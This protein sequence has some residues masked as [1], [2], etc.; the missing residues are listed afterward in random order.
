MGMSQKELPLPPEV[1][2]PKEGRV[3]SARELHANRAET[4][5]VVKHMGDQGIWDQIKAKEV[6]AQI[7]DYVHEAIQAGFELH[8]VRKQLGI[9][10]STDKAW[11]KINAALL[12]G[13]RIDSGSL[14]VRVFSKNNRILA[15][16]DE[17]ILEAFNT[18]VPVKQR[19]GSYEI[20]KGPTKELADMIKARTVVE[21]SMIRIGKDLGAFVDRDSGRGN[22]GVTIVVKSG[23]VLPT[24]TQVDEANKKTIEISSEAVGVK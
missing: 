8:H 17:Q 5:A 7:I 23:V 3:K 13:Y 15:K 14:L 6:P 20:V 24:Q 22:S 4:A 21:Q 19:D 18:G 16:I 1:K 2:V 11:Q 10:R 9:P 12:S